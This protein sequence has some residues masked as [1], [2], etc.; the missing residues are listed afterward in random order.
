MQK[1]ISNVLYCLM[2]C[3]KTS[4][5]R[6]ETGLSV[7]VANM[8]REYTLNGKL[9]AVWTKIPNEGKRSRISGAIL[10]AM[11]LIPGAFDFVFVWKDGGGWIELKL[12]DDTT[13]K[14]NEN[15]RN[16][17]AWCMHKDVNHALCR[18]PDEVAHVLKKWGAL[19]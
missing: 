14:F 8:L 10:K 12:P 9:K 4:N 6:G 1:S 11:G 17:S 13:S 7:Q 2:Y 18:S 16:F 3:P 15:Q 19:R 5:L